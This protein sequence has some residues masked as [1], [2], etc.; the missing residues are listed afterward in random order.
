[1][2]TLKK[3]NST[4]FVVNLTDFVGL[5]AVWE[6]Q[7][8][9]WELLAITRLT[10]AILLCNKSSKTRLIFS[11]SVN[12]NR[13]IPKQ[14]GNSDSNPILLKNKNYQRILYQIESFPGST[15][16]SLSEK[17]DIG[18]VACRRYLQQLQFLKE[19]YACDSAVDNTKV[20]YLLSKDRHQ[21][22]DSKVASKNITSISNL[23]QQ[24]YKTS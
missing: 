13:V 23:N 8:G 2:K 11:T 1:M 21:T 15:L 18:V 6:C 7:D 17:L 19:I 12:P 16:F 5:I 9:Y 10:S 22:S 3:A 24:T 20:Y 4:K 14:L